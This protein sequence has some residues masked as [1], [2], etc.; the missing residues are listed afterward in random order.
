M[1]GSRR[2]SL[3]LSH[4]L[5]CGFDL[6]KSKFIAIDSIPFIPP[7]S[8]LICQMAIKSADTGFSFTRA[9]E[10]ETTLTDDVLPSANSWGISE[11]FDRLRLGCLQEETRIKTSRLRTH[12]T[13]LR[14]HWF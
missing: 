12:I 3:L 7:S 9:V 1:E 4:M 10:A 14:K 2:L 13:Y 6:V 8:V 11:H 5:F